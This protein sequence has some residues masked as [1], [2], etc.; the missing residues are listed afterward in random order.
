MPSRRVWRVCN[1]QHQKYGPQSIIHSL[2]FT[3]WFISKAQQRRQQQCCSSLLLNNTHSARFSYRVKHTKQVTPGEQLALSHTNVWSYLLWL[4]SATSLLL[5]LSQISNHAPTNQWLT[6]GLLF[7][8]F[9][10]INNNSGEKQL[11][12]NAGT[13]EDRKMNR[14]LCC[15]VLFCFFTY[16]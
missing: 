3:H 4:I 12:H 5:P 8:L 2:S 9:L 15:L 7:K 14:G 6:L 1:K 13:K 11:R 16:I 10:F